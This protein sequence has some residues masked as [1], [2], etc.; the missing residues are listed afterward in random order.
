MSSFPR[1]YWSSLLVVGLAI[2]SCAE[3]VLMT[4]AAQARELSKA[5]L[6]VRRQANSVSLVIAG[7]GAGARLEKQKQSSFSWEARITSP[8][9]SGLKRGSQQ[10]ISLPTAGLESVM[11]LEAGN[12]YILRVVPDD[13]TT[14]LP[15]Q[16]S[17]NGQD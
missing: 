3:P 9:A 1:R 14:L 5:E 12:D 11:L 2:T 17:A 15:P 8:E 7:V 13:D 4:A 16:I 6:Q 10:Q